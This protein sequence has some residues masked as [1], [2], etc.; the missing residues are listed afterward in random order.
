MSA[1]I[2]P[3]KH[4]V[5]LAG[6]QAL[7]AAAEGARGSCDDAGSAGDRVERARR[8]EAG[9]DA[10]GIGDIDADIARFRPGRD[11]LVPR[12]ELRDDGPAKDAARADDENAQA[13]SHDCPG[14]D[15]SLAAIRRV[16][17]TT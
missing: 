1:F 7:D 12:G 6:L 14:S 3:S 16:R 2:E 13:I 8:P 10:G 11:D 15:K 17:G 9:L 4:P 5:G